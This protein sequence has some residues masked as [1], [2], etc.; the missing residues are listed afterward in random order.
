M[1]QTQTLTETFVARASGGFS[2]AQMTALSGV[3]SRAVESCR[4]QWR[5]V[6][7]P[8]AV[9][10]RHLAERLPAPNADSPVEALLGQLS[11]AEL[12]L[13]C[14][15]LHR[16]PEAL[17]VFE[18]SYLAKL[19]GLLGSM[20]EPAAT[21][22]EICQLVRVR[23]LVGT[24]DNGPRIAEYA[25]RGSLLSWLRV[26]ASRVALKLIAANPPAADE[27]GAALLEALPAP[28]MDLE[29]DLIKRRYHTEFRD[30]VREAFSSLSKD[31][32]HLLRLYFVDRLSTPE[33]GGLFRVHQSTAFRWLQRAQ[34][35]VYEETKRRLQAR[36]GFATQE[37]KSLF[38]VLDSQLG[39]T[40][41]QMLG[42]EDAV[43]RAQ[44]AS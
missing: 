39:L 9:F 3:L 26:I 5:G 20:K 21:I 38:A 30:A 13:A 15:C 14:A 34:R 12:Y 6:S 8:A 10:V 24:R 16:D 40:I 19:P 28:G 18:R 44:A 25:G 1:E 41:S 33:L 23:V 42:T 2:P 29:L 35:A 22:D 36:L 31:D 17:A 43:A 7:I 37:F 32:R 27:S 4:A 11:L